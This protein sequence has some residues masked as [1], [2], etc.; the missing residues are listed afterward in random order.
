MRNINGLRRPYFF[1]SVER[2][3]EKK[4]RSRGAIAR[5]SAEVRDPACVRRRA[6]FQGG[7]SSPLGT[8]SGLRR[9]YCVLIYP[10][11]TTAQPL[12]RKKSNCGGPNARALP[13]EPSGPGYG[14]QMVLHSRCRRTG[15]YTIQRLSGRRRWILWSTAKDRGNMFRSGTVR[16]RFLRGKHPS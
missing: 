5:T 13:A 14:N 7:T 16:G 9:G 1:R 11:S 3:M 8:P 10:A 2:N 15:G 4:D 12:N 6:R